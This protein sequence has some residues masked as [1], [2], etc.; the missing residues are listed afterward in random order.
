MCLVLGSDGSDSS[1][2]ASWEDVSSLSGAEVGVRRPV[3]DLSPTRAFRDQFR[4]SISFNSWKEE[5]FGCPTI[6]ERSLPHSH[7]S[8]DEVNNAENEICELQETKL[9]ELK[10]QAMIQEIQPLESKDDVKKALIPLRNQLTGPLPSKKFLDLILLHQGSLQDDDS[11]SSP[12]PMCD[13]PDSLQELQT[14]RIPLDTRTVDSAEQY[15]QEVWGQMNTDFDC[16][17]LASEE[18]KLSHRRTWST[19]PLDSFTDGTQSKARQLRSIARKQKC[20]KESKREKSPSK[21]KQK[22]KQR[23]LKTK[24]T[25]DF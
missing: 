14:R 23:N 21:L 25:F 15:N 8:S 13:S 10:D 16:A 24:R 7:R 2:F 11:L 20:L 3:L 22:S 12:P 5:D 1:Q 9:E 6:S 18:S 17:S 4:R 19:E